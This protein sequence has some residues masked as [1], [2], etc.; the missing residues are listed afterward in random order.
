MNAIAKNKVLLSIIAILLLA[1]IGILV[2]FLGLRNPAN[3][4]THAPESVHKSFSEFLRQEVG[5][6]EEQMNQLQVL[7]KEHKSIIKPLFDDLTRTKEDFFNHIDDSTLTGSRLDSAAKPI[8]DKQV[9]VDIQTFRH[10][11]NLRKLCTDEQ[12]PKFDS[13]FPEVVKR[14]TNPW[15]KGKHYKK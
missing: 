2:F 14:M 9:L 4:S 5:F 1:N 13:L 10:F 6:S 3:A 7:K 8:G 11:R 15:K 12:K